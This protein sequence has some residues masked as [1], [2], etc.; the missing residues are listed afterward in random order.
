MAGINEELF[1][2]I[3]MYSNYRRKEK[4]DHLE[5]SNLILFLIK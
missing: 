5:V 2:H 4:I 3:Q 1:E